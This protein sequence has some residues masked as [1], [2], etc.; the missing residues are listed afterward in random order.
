MTPFRI[1][2]AIVLYGDSITQLAFGFGGG[3][4][5]AGLLASAYTRRADVL[6][7]GF[8]GYNTSHALEL[9][10]RVFGTFQ[11]EGVLFATVFFGAN[12]AQLPGHPQHV[13]IE[14]YRANLETLV[15]RIRSS[16]ASP[17]PFPII[18]I[19]PPPVEETM[20]KNFREVPESDRLN[21]VARDYGLTMQQVGAKLGCPVLDTWELLDGGS[22]DR[23]KY[24][25]DGL[26]LNELGNRLVYQGLMRLIQTEF[27]HLAPMSDDDGEGKFGKSGIP[28]EEK[29]WK[30]L[31]GLE[32]Q[33]QK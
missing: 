19:T 23:A 13:P 10:P 27:P 17:Q 3:V 15:E 14:Q 24:L 5:W 12:D 21:G 1:R 32:D 4:G 7:R 16:V 9:L 6:N 29:L 26:H 20:W 8:S 28:V 31:V 2:P 33:I 11:N 25:G 30:E 22:S 18:L